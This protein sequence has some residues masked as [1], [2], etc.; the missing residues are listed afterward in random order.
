[1]VHYIVTLDTLDKCCV[2]HILCAK[3][4]VIMIL[5]RICQPNLRKERGEGRGEGRRRG[6][7]G[8]SKHIKHPYK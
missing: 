3:Y 1:M 6:E 4:T 8:T 2:V 7:G 5:V